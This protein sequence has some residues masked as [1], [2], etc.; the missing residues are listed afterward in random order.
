MRKFLAGMAWTVLMASSL[1]SAPGAS[2]HDGHSDWFKWR[3]PQPDSD[4]TGD[5]VEIKAKV[6]FP[7]E[8]VDRWIVEVLPPDGYATLPGFGTVCEGDI[9]DQDEKDEGRGVE[10][11]CRWDSTR[12]P[13]GTPS[14]N[15]AYR[16]QV[17]AWHDPAGE[18]ENTE[19]APDGEGT[20]DGGE[21]ASSDEGADEGG[22][23]QAGGSDGPST[24][25]S[26]SS[27]SSSSTTTTTPPAED[28]AHR[29]PTRTVVVAN[30]P[31]A[32]E[33][34]RLSY[35]EKTAEVTVRWNANE[36]PDIA[37]YLV[38]ERFNSGDWSLVAKPTGTSWKGRLKEKGRY[39]YRVAAV[40]YVGSAER[41]VE[42][43]YREPQ[44][45][46]RRVQADPRNDMAESTEEEESG[47]AGGADKDEDRDKG[48]DEGKDRDKGKD[49]RKNQGASSTT[50]TRPPE[51]TIVTFRGAPDPTSTT[52]TR[53][54]LP[55]PGLSTIQPGSPGSVQT[56]YA[57]PP[58]L[59]APVP[60]EQAYDPGFSMSLPYPEEV[61]LDIVPPPPE[62]PRLLGSMVLFE[63]NEEQRRA[64]VGVL[65]ASLV[66]FMLAMQFAYLNRRPRPI[67][68]AASSDWD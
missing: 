44:S 42:G 24:S 39:R 38:Q 8:G 41:L 34:V 3:E 46:P 21:S 32:P 4:V 14:R 60:P 50:T 30:P 28:N 1:A 29:S 58:E 18:P 31:E 19:E 20:D 2:A 63:D 33:G 51:S 62:P 12:Y 53:P 54:P 25:T 37:G 9:P 15:H 65:A 45:D 22:D 40:R 13:D 16:L 10:I 6:E 23:E 11:S 47:P 36:E 55:K 26:S 52:A 57:D 66:V 59:P 5:A 27:T 7:D 67:D 17:T 56:R 35:A 48:R 64:L 49:R 43:P 61:R 68:L